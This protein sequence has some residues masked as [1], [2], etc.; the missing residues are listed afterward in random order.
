MTNTSPFTPPSGRTINAE[1]FA[2]HFD[3][4]AVLDLGPFSPGPAFTLEAWVRPS[5]VFGKV[6]IYAQPGFDG[7]SRSLPAGHYND[8][9]ACLRPGTSL[10]LRCRWW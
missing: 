5:D 3:G 8:V 1:P 7:L 2:I 9:S 10:P 6:K 4:S